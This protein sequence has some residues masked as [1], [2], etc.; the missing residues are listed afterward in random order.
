MKNISREDIDLLRHNAR[1]V[2]RE[3]GLLNDA[4]FEIGVTLA[5][6]HLLIEL[7][8]CTYPT[9]GEI[10]GRLLLDKSTVSRLIA[11]AIKKGYIHCS[12]DDKDKR[13]RFLHLTE[14]G[15]KTLHAF[16]PIAFNQTK[17]ALLTLTAEEI[18]LVY[19][20]VALYAKGLKNSRLQSKTPVLP[21]EMA[22]KSNAD[23]LEIRKQL[24]QLGFTLNPFSQEDKNSLYDIFQD[25]V[26][27]GNQFPYECNSIE[28]FYRQF[29]TPTS[30]IYVCHSSAKEVV[31]GFYV[32]SNF[33]GRSSHIANAAYMIKKNYRG[34]GIGTLLV[35]A[36]LEIA[37]DLGFQAMQF[38][39]VFSQNIAAIK[40]YQKL[41]FNI[42]GT[43]PQ[44]I[45]NPD[46]SYQDGYILHRNLTV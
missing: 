9:M 13:K 22:K 45:R 5:E 7:N 12:L 4:Y 36:S 8:T 43:V 26:D 39:M 14:L 2:I 25:V 1:N 34:Q 11:K 33:S 10:A 18:K 17:E 31:G 24:T 38:N 42:I 35:N 37:K 16:E 44:A 29:L 6:R 28:E 23:L 27:S 21:E 46:K 40:L 30:H 20:G 19:Q 3:L 32:R 41:G 15:E